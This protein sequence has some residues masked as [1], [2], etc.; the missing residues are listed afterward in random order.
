LNILESFSLARVRKPG[1]LTLLTISAMHKKVK[2]IVRR[3]KIDKSDGDSRAFPQGFL[4]LLETAAPYPDSLDVF[5][6]RKRPKAV[7]E[8]HLSQN[9][10]SGPTSPAVSTS[11]GTA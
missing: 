3:T 2:N 4:K 8:H 6:I 5:T 9:S 11:G 7:L 10:G 1:S